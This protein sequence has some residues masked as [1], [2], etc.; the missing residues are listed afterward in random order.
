MY[1]FGPDTDPAEVS[2]ALDAGEHFWLD[3][4]LD[5][6]DADHPVARAL[7]VTEQ[8]LER[9]K[10]RDGRSLA[11]V[12]HGHAAIVFAGAARE[13]GRV[14]RIDVVIIAGGNAL[15]TLHDSPSEA[16]DKLRV[17]PRDVDALYV[18]DALTDGLLEVADIMEEQVEAAENSILQ[19]RSRQALAELSALRQQVSEL[20]KIAR[21]QRGMVER[22][23]DELSDIPVRFGTSER[24]VRD[25]EN[26][27]ARATY[28]A[29]STRQTIAEALNLYL[30]IAAENLTRIAT[31]LLPL[32]VVSGFF[33]MN[34]TWMVDHIDTMWSFLVFGIGGMIASVTGVRLYLARKGYE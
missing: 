21:E 28:A 4:P 23:Q 18:L 15:V 33:G 34:F 27:L 26:H 5:S 30:S 16:L 22:S 7:G 14:R 17:S 8:R 12:E 24:R 11:I 2:R 20:L 9:L 29:D 3:L 32:T 31:V 10:R 13:S 6:F 1:V 19:T 25:L